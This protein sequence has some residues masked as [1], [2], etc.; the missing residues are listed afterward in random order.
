MI[1]Y[2][3]EEPVTN[4]NFIEALMDKLASETQDKESEYHYTNLTK[5]QEEKVGSMIFIGD[6]TYQRIPNG[7]WRTTKGLTSLEFLSSNELIDRYLDHMN[8]E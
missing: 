7:T 5:I 6:H 1:E 8:G 2:L 3:E 4:D